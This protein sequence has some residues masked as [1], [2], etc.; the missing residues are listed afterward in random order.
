MSQ[1]KG[2]QLSLLLIV[3]KRET[4][5]CDEGML[6]NESHNITNLLKNNRNQISFTNSII[7]RV[8]RNLV[9][10]NDTPRTKYISAP[11]IKGTS[12]RVGRTL[13]EHNIK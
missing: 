1:K 10:I 3:N 9:H 12:A 11:Y 4:N 6:E 7:N 5:L 13:R 8:P 2:Q